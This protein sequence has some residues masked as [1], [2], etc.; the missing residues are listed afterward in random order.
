MITI[1]YFFIEKNKG[2]FIFIENTGGNVGLYLAPDKLIEYRIMNR[3]Y[4]DTPE[5]RN[6]W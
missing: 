1:P 5:F 2:F 3:V 4:P 6:L